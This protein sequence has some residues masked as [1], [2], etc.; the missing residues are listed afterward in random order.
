MSSIEDADATET[1]EESGGRRRQYLDTCVKLQAALGRQIWQ[2][3]VLEADGPPPYWLTQ[4][5]RRDDWVEAAALRRRIG[6]AI[7]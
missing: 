2:T 6:A 1:W 5:D 3:N 4:R 7:G